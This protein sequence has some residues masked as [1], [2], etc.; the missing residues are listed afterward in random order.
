[1]SLVFKKLYPNM[2]TQYDEFL[3]V[4]TDRSQPI[5]RWNGYLYNIFVNLTLFSISLQLI[6]F[7]SSTVMIDLTIA[8]SYHL[9]HRWSI[10]Y[11]LS[12]IFVFCLLAPTNKKKQKLG[13]SISL[14]GTIFRFAWW[15]QFDVELWIIHQIFIII[16]HD[17]NQ[18]YKVPVDEITV[19]NVNIHVVD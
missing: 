9:Q 18:G 12:P 10:D 17:H 8:I 13:L 5:S 4:E 2:I 19:H 1:M 14:G 7:H 6:N 3:W 15:E 16:Y 11:C